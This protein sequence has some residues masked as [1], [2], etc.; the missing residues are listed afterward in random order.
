MLA[1]QTHRLPVRGF[2]S[3][4]P[5]AGMFARLGGEMRSVLAWVRRLR[6][7]L[8]GHAMVLRFEPR[9]V[10][11]QCYAC[12]HNTPGWQVAGRG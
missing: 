9:R 12:G 3:T 11:L 7:G 4:N 2:P 5:F 1:A 10:S 6:C 8:G